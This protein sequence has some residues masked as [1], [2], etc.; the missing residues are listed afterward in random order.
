MNELHTFL[1]TVWFILLG[2]VITLYALLDGCELGT[3]ILSLLVRPSL[4]NGIPA[5]TTSAWG[6]NELW[7]LLAGGILFGA[8]PHAFML[9]EHNLRLPLA[10]LLLGL[11]MRRTGVIHNQHGNKP[12]LAHGLRGW[13]SLLTAVIQGWLL[14]AV[15]GSFPP[16]WRTPMAFAGSVAVV[17]GYSL[18]GVCYLRGHRTLLRAGLAL[19]MLIIGALAINLYPDIFPGHLTLTEA[20]APNQT[21]LFMILGFS[22]LLPV[23]VAYN[24]F[25]YL[26]FSHRAGQDNASTQP[27]AA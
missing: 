24:G 6:I 25:H 27:P 1:A 21:L 3:G 11:I 19:L 26:L 9:I 12:F 16:I 14:G 22:L 15:Y 20:A 5:N 8:F 4:E 2:L 23:I 7:L 17:L 18:L 10:L 13:G